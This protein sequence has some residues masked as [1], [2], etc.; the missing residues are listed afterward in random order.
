MKWTARRIQHLK[1]KQPF[2]TVT[3]TDAVSARLAD[4]AGIPLLL[5]GDSLGMT[6]LGLDST[7][8]VTMEHML[9]HTRACARGTQHAL[10]VA[11]LPFLS[12]QISEE[13]ALRNAGRFLQEAGADAVKLEGG[14]QRAPLIRRMVENGIPVLGHIGLT[15]QSV[16]TLGY[17]VQ[18]KDEGAAE[19]LHKDAEALQAAGCFGLVIE[20][21]PANLAREITLNLDIPVIG[22]G[23]GSE[24]DAQI[25]VFHDLLGL[26][27]EPRPKFVKVYAELGET[28]RSALQEYANEVAERQY[29]ASE[30]LYDS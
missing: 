14:E 19:Q 28:V 27:P 8:E 30:H 9:H 15:P 17:R 6:V 4:E 1:G 29:P 18:G 2:A 20:A 3:V 13:E 25:L 7:V 12:Y 23:A 26:S 21:C 24:C 10:L 5:V 16:K 11:D 22:I